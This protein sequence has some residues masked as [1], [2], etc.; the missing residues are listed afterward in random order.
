M[1]GW[2]LFGAISMFLSVALGAFGAHG[3]KGTISD[4][5]LAVYETGVHYQMIHGLAILLVAV[6]MGQWNTSSSLLGA[7]NWAF[8]IGTFL[9]SGSLYLLAITGVRALGAITPFGGIAFLTGWF[10]LAWAAWKT[11]N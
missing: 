10:L 7:A 2:T 11:R 3:L 5:S 1:S 8:L 6:L 9:F 4:Y